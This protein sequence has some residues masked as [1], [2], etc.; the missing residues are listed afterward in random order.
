MI[1]S[2]GCSKVDGLI[3]NSQSKS[4][5]E[6]EEEEEAEIE[7]I[8]IGGPKSTTL[9]PRI[10][11]DQV[12]SKW[13]FEA[14]DGREYEWVDVKQAWVPVID[15]SLWFAQ[16]AAYRV[17]GVDETVCLFSFFFFSLLLP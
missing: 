13:K 16:Q 10:H 1:E 9:D 15:E 11:F 2:Q 12:T 14:E 7:G 17:E 4:K 6:E 5:Q 8:G 3:S